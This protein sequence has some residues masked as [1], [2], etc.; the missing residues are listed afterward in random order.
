MI[1]GFPSIGL[2]LARHLIPMDYTQIGLLFSVGALA[3][4]LLEPLCNLLSDLGSKK[5]WLLGSLVVL[6]AGWLLAG[7]AR[8]FVFLLV[9][10]VLIYPSNDLTVGIAQT[11]LIDE[12]P[13]DSTRTMTR[14]T[15]LSNIGDFLAP[16]CVTIITVLSLHWDALSWIGA[17][18]WAGM[19][20]LVLSQRFAAPRREA[21][22]S[23]RQGILAGLR[24]ALRDPVLV[25]WAVLALLPVMLDEVF[26]AFVILY[27]QDH[28]HMSEALT[29][30]LITLETLAGFLGLLILEI[31][32]AQRM[33]PRRLLIWSAGGVL[34][35]M[36]LLLSVP[37]LVTAALALA[38]IGAASIC[39]YPLI[40]AEAYRRLP[41]RS[42]TVRALLSLS[43]PFAVILP[44]VVGLISGRFGIIAGLSFLGLA[45]LVL[46]IVIMRLSDTPPESVSLS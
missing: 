16:V 13:H 6:V 31:L 4:M 7:S 32:L 12:N 26:R 45:P 25:S 10:F 21:T 42:G 43:S 41:G 39:W 18:L 19:T 17:V 24:E 46:L 20:L 40:R 11:A 27:L 38:V 36:L 30:L 8:S 29:D 1:S 22:C 37:T 3:S 2:P 33:T 44:S 9:S 34:L 35:G 23:L 15:W 14:Y 28:L 5:Y